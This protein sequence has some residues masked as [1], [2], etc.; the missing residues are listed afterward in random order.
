MTCQIIG[1]PIVCSA[2]CSGSDQRKHKSSATLVFCRGIHRWPVDSPH[3]GP[4]TRKMFPFDDVIMDKLTHIFKIRW[5]SEFLC[6]RRHL[7]K[8]RGIS[9]VKFSKQSFIT[10]NIGSLAPD[11]TMWAPAYSQW[12]FIIP[13][14]RHAVNTHRPRLW[15]REEYTPGLFVIMAPYGVMHHCYH[16]LRLWLVAWRHQATT[17]TNFGLS[18]IR[19]LRT[20]FTYL[21]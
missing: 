13:P 6:R 4:V 11:F 14:C 8:S 1:V 10:A 21:W 12:V 7:V 16:R 9:H 2:V 19:I 15:L 20:H 3:K 17:W 18:S 5:I